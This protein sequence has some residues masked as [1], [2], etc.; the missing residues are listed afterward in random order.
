MSSLK[1]TFIILFVTAFFPVM[2]SQ[3]I[4][5]KGVIS[6]KND[7]ENI[8]VLNITSNHITLTDRD[9]KFNIGV[10][11][12]DI[13]RFSSVQ[14]ETINI[15]V[16]PKIILA[17]NINVELE[18]SIN[19]LEEVVISKGNML[20]GN[21]AY[22]IKNSDTKNKINPYNLNIAEHTWKPQTQNE[23]R[24]YTAT[25]GVDKVLNAI[26][27]RTK[28]IK[29]YI[30]MD[31]ANELLKH[32]KSKYLKAFC[33]EENLN[34]DLRIN[35]LFFCREDPAFLKR[36]QSDNTL[37]IFSFLQEKLKEYKKVIVN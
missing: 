24:L 32:I 3:T 34:E 2:Y 4:V 6:G 17:K 35:F 16:N 13:L 9:G 18:E 11:E 28:E 23:R 1:N 22:D 5:I 31:K 26:S 29:N 19:N 8:S 14:Y 30:E 10:E 27:G 12:N 37:D 25:T 36:C 20:T 7:V 15:I 33:D 21:L